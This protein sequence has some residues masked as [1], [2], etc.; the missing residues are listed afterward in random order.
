MLKDLRNQ[1]LAHQK[2]SE[3]LQQKLNEAYGDVKVIMKHYKH[4]DLF[5]VVLI[6]FGFG[7]RANLLLL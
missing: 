4:V 5:F 1:K 6:L 2:H 3:V 7:S